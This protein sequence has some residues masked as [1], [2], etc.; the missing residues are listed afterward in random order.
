MDMNY[1]NYD[2]IIY[3]NVGVMCGGEEI[4]MNWNYKIDK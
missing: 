4:I 2:Y 3:Y 1:W